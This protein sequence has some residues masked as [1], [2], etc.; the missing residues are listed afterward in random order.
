M[1]RF[2]RYK[3]FKV[4]CES[5]RVPSRKSVYF[6][7][8][9]FILYFSY[10]FHVACILLFTVY[11]HVPRTLHFTMYFRTVISMLLFLCY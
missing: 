5:G 10:N 1:Y 7:I 8:S 2:L 11:F 6:D 9:N 4:Q 3:I